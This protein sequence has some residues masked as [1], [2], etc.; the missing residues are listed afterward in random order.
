M[1][2]LDAVAARSG[3]VCVVGAGG[4]KTALYRLAGLAADQG[5]RSAVTATVRIP[6]FD[7]QVAGVRTTSDPAAALSGT[8][9]WPAGVVPERDGE[10]RYRGYDTAVIDDLA[11]SGAADVLLIK[12]DGAR[13]REF[14]APG[15]REPQ[16]PASAT[17]VLPIASAHAVGEPLTE[18]VVH[19]PERVAAITGLDH[20][21]EITAADVATVL[22]SPVGG[23]KGVPEGATVI[24][25]V[26]KVDDAE[27]R[28]V[29]REIARGVLDRSAVPRVVLTRLVAPDPLVEVVR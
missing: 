22:A 6:I 14:K 19:R 9:E 25:I 1:D 8:E 24:P 18:A 27:L 12:A 21:E 13:T 15:D 10:D 4:K 5:V 16:L 7:A 28:G 11:N 23:R 17:T 26:N 20:G 29:G 2:L 3:V